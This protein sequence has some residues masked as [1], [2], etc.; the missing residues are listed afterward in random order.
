MQ[1]D[2]TEQR[3][4]GLMLASLDGDAAS[5]RTLLAE[6]SRH[7]RS[8]FL[9]RLT[10]AYAAQA[11]DLVQDMLLRPATRRCGL[12]A[13]R[14]PGHTDGRFGHGIQAR[15]PHLAPFCVVAGLG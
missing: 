12:A 2:S 3:L 1:T 14:G 9:R 5:Y 7:L 11:D 10:P 13:G 15:A 4:R 8:Y 6:L